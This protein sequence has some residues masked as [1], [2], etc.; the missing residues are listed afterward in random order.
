MEKSPPGGVKTWK[1][2]LFRI[3]NKIVTECRF[4][5]VFCETSLSLWSLQIT[6]K[7]TGSRV[8][9][10]LKFICFWT[11]QQ[12]SRVSVKI[13][14][15][16]WFPTSLSTNCQFGIQRNTRHNLPWLN[17]KYLGSLVLGS[18]DPLLFLSQARARRSKTDRWRLYC[19]DQFILCSLEIWH[20]REVLMSEMVS[21][22]GDRDGF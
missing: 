12:R 8:G 14:C 7:I 17:Y 11:S 21:V 4:V 13:L 18:S 15:C 16:L 5:V 2:V 6:I 19:P 3:L 10:G 22:N 1:R 20:F 9:C